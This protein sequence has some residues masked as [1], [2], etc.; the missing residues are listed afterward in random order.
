V[1]RPDDRIAALASSQH[2]AFGRRQALDLGMTRAAIKYRIATRRWGVLEPGVY[3]VSGAGDSAE[4]RVVAAI[5]ACGPDAIASHLTAAWLWGLIE[6]PPRCVSVTVPHGQHHAQLP[7]RV[8]HQ[9]RNLQPSDRKRVRRI[10]TTCP[11]RT[12]VDIAGVLP[13][14]KLAAALDTAVIRGLVSLTSLNRYICDRRL[15]RLRGVGR[16][17]ALILDRARG[18]PEGELERRF[19]PVVR[20]SGLP[21]PVRQKRSGR[22]RI[23]YA[24][25]DLKIMIELDGWTY[26]RTPA[27]LGAD[28]KRQNELVLSGWI[29]LRFTW[30]DIRE[31]SAM[32]AAL[33]DL[34]HQRL[35]A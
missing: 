31:G 19:L 18:I 17:Q 13:E 20:G 2:N 9:V 25:P 15:G 4:Q 3:C 24:Y 16:L 7:Q 22:Y 28:N 11:N 8:T 34:Y 30:D 1:Q 33:V 6:L 32:L 26:H 10:P 14:D 23:D 12:L 5:I 29:P 27:Q 35:G 21:E